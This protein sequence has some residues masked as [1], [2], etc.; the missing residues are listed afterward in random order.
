MGTHDDVILQDGKIRET[1]RVEAAR[2]LKQAEAAGLTS[3]AELVD[4]EMAVHPD[5]E[6]WEGLSFTV[7]GLTPILMHKAEGNLGQNRTRGTKTKEKPTPEQEAPRY[8]YE[9]A[10]GNLVVPAINMRACLV[11]AGKRFPV[12]GK[13]YSMNT[14]LSGALQLDV[15]NLLF[16]LFRD[17]KQVREWV[18]DVRRV[19]IQSAGIERGRPKIVDPWTLTCNFLLDRDSFTSDHEKFMLFMEGLIRTAGKQ[20]GI[21]DFRPACNGWFGTFRL[22]SIKLYKLN[23]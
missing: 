18:L 22:D 2:L 12:E 21:C 5:Y 3:I 15:D 19:R 14:I 7:S 20:I 4:Q 13:R 11:Q 9:D 6:N 23:Y 1:A 17:G 8:T 16:P 10:V